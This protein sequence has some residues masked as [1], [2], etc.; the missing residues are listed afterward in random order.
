MTED[1]MVREHHRLN[2]HEFEQILGDSEE[3]GS[4]ACCSPRG[5]KESDMT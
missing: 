1:K 3:Q 5:C 4:V 2:R